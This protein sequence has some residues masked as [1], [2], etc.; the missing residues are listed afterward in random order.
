[1]S[2][3]LAK[4]RQKFLSRD[5]KQAL[6]DKVTH[7]LTVRMPSTPHVYDVVWNYEKAMLYF[8]SNLRSANEEL[9]TLF[10]SS[11]HLAL[12]RMFPYT[13][14][15]IRSDL[16]DNERDALTGLSPTHFSS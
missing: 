7:E 11:F 9:E 3:R 13:A 10:K 5:E 8:F 16:S 12:I 14:A 6:R 1:M 4:T 15:D 2:K